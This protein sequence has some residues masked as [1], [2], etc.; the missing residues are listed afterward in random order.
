MQQTIE[1]EFNVAMQWF[2]A[3]ASARGLEKYDYIKHMEKQCPSAWALLLLYLNPSNVFHIRAKSLANDIKPD[4]EP[5]TSVKPMIN[6]LMA[7]PAV[8]NKMIAKIK[9]TLNTILDESVRQFAVQYLTKTVKIGIT[10]DTVNKALEKNI[11]PVF[12][13]MLANKY[14]DHPQ[15]VVGKTVAVTEKLD[16][17]RA[18]AFV[19]QWPQ[20]ADIA[21]FSRQGKRIYGLTEVE[22]AIREAVVPLYEN[23][24]L[25]DNVVFDGELLITNRTGIPSKEQYKQTTKIVSSNKLIQ[26]TGI[27]Y[28]V[29]DVLPVKD[30]RIGESE[31]IYSQRRKALE[32][33]FRGCNSPAVRVVPVEQTF[34]LPTKQALTEPL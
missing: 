22:N 6:D 4:G 29:F 10:A 14:F 28:N 30:F 1:K 20:H 32:S 23:E 5:Y 16:G 12:G 11:I 9:A 15:A 19:Q 27:T 18:L 33:I 26:K 31:A 7:M 34:A 24:T 8:T 21:I 2:H 3:V 13:C 25:E 17:I